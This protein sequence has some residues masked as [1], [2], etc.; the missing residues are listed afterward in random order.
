MSRQLQRF[1]CNASCKRTKCGCGAFVDGVIRDGAAISFPMSI[2]DA[3]APPA[4]TGSVA[5]TDQQEQDRAKARRDAAY[6]AYVHNLNTAH[7]AD[8]A[9]DVT[10][11][12]A[13][14]DAQTLLAN[15]ERARASYIDRLQNAWRQGSR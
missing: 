9:E 14:T 1:V 10:L 2:T 5:L 4:E 7:M 12:S 3:G 13:A 15:R 11:R 6:D 8:G